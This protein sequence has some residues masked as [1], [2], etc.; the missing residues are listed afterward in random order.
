M[1]EDEDDYDD[2]EF[3]EGETDEK[4]LPNMPAILQQ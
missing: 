4:T 1:N 3:E 2:Q